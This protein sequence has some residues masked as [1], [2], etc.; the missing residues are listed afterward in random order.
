[1]THAAYFFSTLLASLLSPLGLYLEAMLLTMIAPLRWI[2]RHR[3]RLAVT[4]TLLFAFACTDFCGKTMLSAL[5]HL[6]VVSQPPTTRDAVYIVLGGGAVAEGDIY[7]PSIASQR[8]LRHARAL[9]DGRENAML[10]LSGI[11]APVM[12]RWLGDTPRLV[13]AHS[14]S[15]QQNVELSA[16]LLRRAFP[17][18]RERPA[19]CFVTDRFHTFRALLYAR[20][21]MADFD[22]YACPA[23]SLVRRSPWR[24]FHFIPTCGGLSVTSMAWRETLAL[25][26]DWLRGI[27]K[28]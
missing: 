26:R 13:E 17:D 12:V 28:G 8:R 16:R 14:L 7:Q 10:M 27:L 20:L 21:A 11:E 25:T 18:E 9:V 3:R 19:V 6:A 24:L 1:M 5:E 2:R 22:V 4:F 15:T 23:A